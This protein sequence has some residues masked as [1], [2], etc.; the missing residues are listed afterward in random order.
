MHCLNTPGYL[1]FREMWYKNEVPSFCEKCHMV[2][3]KPID[4]PIELPVN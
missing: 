3:L 4:L 2:D 1:E